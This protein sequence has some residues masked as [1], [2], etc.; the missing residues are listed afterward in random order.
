MT[1][2]MK[3]A[4]ALSLD[5]LEADVRRAFD[6]STASPQPVKRPAEPQFGIK[7][8][9]P[10]AGTLP[11]SAVLGSPYEALFR[12]VVIN[13]SGLALVGAAWM[14]GWVTTVMSADDTGLTLAIFA[15]FISGLAV[16][17][18][19]LYRL[20]R[21]IEAVRSGTPRALSWAASYLAA[22][23][24][25][26]ASARAIA[27]SVLKVR[28]GDWI[29][30]VRHVANSLVL[31]GL[32][33]TV[34]GFIISLSGVDPAAVSDVKAISPMVSKLLSGMSVA[35]YTTLAGA[36]LNLWLMV[37]YRLLSS[38]AVRFVASLVER[39]EADEHA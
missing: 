36:M 10:S 24:G 32:I 1:A 6:G 34:I 11:S 5:D 13:L 3:Y 33:G 12:F 22:V 14:Q 20:G 7:S 38:A 21:E 31:L 18:I 2:V 37:N 39:G 27:G 19:K 28:L 30:V 17:G 25:R 23:R 15:V 35:L 26:D 29:S 9:V 8:Q 16:C 4:G